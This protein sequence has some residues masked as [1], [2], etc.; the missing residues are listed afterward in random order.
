M[1]GFNDTFKACNHRSNGNQNQ[2]TVQNINDFLIFE[3]K[4]KICGQIQL[5]F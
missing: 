5:E 1:T 3:L 2:S 4:Q